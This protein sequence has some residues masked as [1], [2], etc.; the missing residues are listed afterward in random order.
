MDVVFDRIDVGEFSFKGVWW[1][2]LVVGHEKPLE[3]L[4]RIACIDILFLFGKYLFQ[5]FDFQEE[6]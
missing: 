2:G 3:E 5:E 6:E 4:I 1:C